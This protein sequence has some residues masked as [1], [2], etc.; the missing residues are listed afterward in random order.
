MQKLV[1]ALTLTLWLNP[2][3]AAEESWLDKGKAMAAEV[4]EK[5]KEKVKETTDDL[6]VDN[7]K[8][9]KNAA[10]EKTDEVVEST[11]TFLGDNEKADEFIDSNTSE[12]KTTASRTTDEV[13]DNAKT[14]LTSD[15]E[16]NSKSEE[17]PWWK[18]WGDK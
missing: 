9:L 7:T 15:S 3:N 18:F 2:I 17:K 13:V 8:K 11:K 5:T 10:S 6:I 1:F 12:L 14:L 4:G 16:T